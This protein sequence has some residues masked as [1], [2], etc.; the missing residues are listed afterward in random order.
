[1]IRSGF[2][3]R[4][5]NMSKRF[6]SLSRS[7][8]LL[9]CFRYASACGD[10]RGSQFFPTRWFSLSRPRMCVR[11]ALEAIAKFFTPDVYSAHAS[12]PGQALHSSAMS[13]IVISEHVHNLHGT[14]TE[15]EFP[16]G[17]RSYKRLTPTEWGND[18]CKSLF[19]AIIPSLAYRRWKGTHK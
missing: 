4:W 18:F 9:A 10:L 15:C 7:L 5:A 2:Y 3:R 8:R 16:R 13:E 6:V 14:P 17:P 19:R 12:R 1:M 11:C